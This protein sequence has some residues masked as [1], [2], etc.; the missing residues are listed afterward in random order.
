[1]ADS[2]TLFPTD[3]FDALMK[4]DLRAEMKKSITI[5]HERPGVHAEGMPAVGGVINPNMSAVAMADHARPGGSDQTT[6]AIDPKKPCT[7]DEVAEMDKAMI[8]GNVGPNMSGDSLGATR[9][10]HPGAIATPAN[11][12]QQVSPGDSQGMPNVQHVQDVIL[13]ADDALMEN[14]LQPRRMPLDEMVPP[15][16]PPQLADSAGTAGVAMFKSQVASYPQGHHGFMPLGPS[17]EPGPSP[18]A[19]AGAGQ[20]QPAF[21]R[22]GS[23]M[24]STGFD[25]SLS[26]AMTVGHGGVFGMM[27]QDGAV[28]LNAP[29]MQN[30]QCRCCQKSVPTFLAGCPSCGDNPNGMQIDPSQMLQKAMGSA[31]LATP[32]VQLGRLHFPNGVMPIPAE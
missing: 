23:V 14:Q 26:K 30:R 6:K 25:Q 21:F 10:E 1:M 7:D 9:T 8:E 32:P 11:A 15:W 4:R 29:L 22:M 19:Q 3:L 28:D 17:S 18:R 27:Y 20:S 24:I 12:A 2:K 16:S 31:G 5:E 13:S